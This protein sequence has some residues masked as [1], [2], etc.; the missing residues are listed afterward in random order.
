MRSDFTP[1]FHR[2]SKEKIW[3][4]LGRLVVYAHN[5]RLTMVEAVSEVGSGLLAVCYRGR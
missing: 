5:H 3:K 2:R 4:H 1:E